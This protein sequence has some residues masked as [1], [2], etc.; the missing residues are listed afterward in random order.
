M[1]PPPDGS[2][3]SIRDRLK[4]P[5]PNEAANSGGDASRSDVSDSS[6]Q[7]TDSRARLLAGGGDEEQRSH[8]AGGEPVETLAA[9][10][11]LT[12]AEAKSAER[13]YSNVHTDV[14]KL[15]EHGLV[16]RAPD[17]T[18]FVPFE[19]VEIHLALFRHAA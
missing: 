4:S 13:N 14:N 16:K 11:D 8:S 6:F 5:V 2:G 12:P 18:V 1:T 17:D 3:D 9:H 10:H 15:E 19:S 7:Q